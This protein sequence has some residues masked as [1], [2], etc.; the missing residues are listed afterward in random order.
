MACKQERMHM[1]NQRRYLNRQ[2]GGVPSLA[3]LLLLFIMILVIPISCIS[4]QQNKRVV[5]ISKHNDSIHAK[6]RNDTSLIHSDT[7]LEGKKIHIDNTVT[8]DSITHL[9]DTNKIFVFRDEKKI[10]TI[11][12]KY[13]WEE[14]GSPTIGRDSI[15]KI[16]FVDVDFDGN[17]DLLIYKGGFGN[18]GADIYDCFLWNDNK[19]QFKIAPSFSYILNPSIDN[20]QKCIYSFSRENASSYVNVKYKFQNGEF[21]AIS[22]LKEKV[23]NGKMVYILETSQN[24]VLHKKI[25]RPADLGEWKEKILTK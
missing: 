5:P 23:D 13:N 7:S 10:Q 2:N 17:K 20:R 3:H 6:I 11:I 12:Y 8:I 14:Y 4:C 19:H 21:R 16:D 25:L 18:Q 22:T 9:P 15:G 1:Q 24:G